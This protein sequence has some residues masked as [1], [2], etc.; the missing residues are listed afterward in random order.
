M[1][2][3][4]YRL[5]LALLVVGPAAAS[6]GTVDRVSANPASAPVGHGITVTVGGT[7]PCGAAFVD[8]GDGTAITYAI[9]GLP[10]SQSHPY[11]KAGRYRIVARG[12][13][14]CDGE[15]TTNVEISG[16]PP[17][18]HPHPPNPPNP[19]AARVTAVTFTSKPA[20]ARQPVTIAVDGE[21]V[22]GFGLDYGDGNQQDFSGALPKRVTHTYGTPG[23]YRVIVGPAAPCTGKFTE[24]LE[25]LP[26]G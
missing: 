17:P 9:T 18:D 24:T 14:N 25:V 3:R 7:N 12:M 26:R 15:A 10:T 22:C 1:T 5:A 21:G 6:A 4:T 13:G 23:T 19:P 16:P 11:G 20:T 2:G 8:W